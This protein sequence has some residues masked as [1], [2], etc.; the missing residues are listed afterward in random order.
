MRD[1]LAIYLNGDIPWTGPNTCPGI[2]LG[3]RQQFLAI[4]A[5][6]AILTASPVF[7]IFCTHLPGGRFYLEL[8]AIGHLAPETKSMLS[9][10]ISNSSKQGLHPGQLTRSHT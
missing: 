6:L 10:I 3:R 2:L 7:L 5:E 4:W 1:G 9:P 8:E